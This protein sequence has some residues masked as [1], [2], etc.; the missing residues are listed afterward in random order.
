VNTDHRTRG[1]RSWRRVSIRRDVTIRLKKLP[2]QRVASKSWT[3]ASASRRRTSP[4]SHARLHDQEERARLSAC[5]RPP[6][7]PPKWAAVFQLTVTGRA[8][9]DLALELPL[10]VRLPAS[11]RHEYRIESTHSA[12]RRQPRDPRGLQE[13]LCESGAKDTQLTTPWPV[14]SARRANRSNSRFE[15]VFRIPRSGSA[16]EDHQSIAENRPYSWPSWTCACRPVG[17]ASETIARMWEVDPRLQAVV[18][19]A[20]AGTI[21]G[22]DDRQA[23]TQRYACLIHRR[24]A[25]SG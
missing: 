14:S 4:A 20:Y 2:L 15:F 17:T 18:C 16:R 23:R 6:T 7:P 19:T 8:W 21:V 9:R 13:I 10:M 25:F 3:T 22:S 12:D 24:E 1:N 5:T 11:Q